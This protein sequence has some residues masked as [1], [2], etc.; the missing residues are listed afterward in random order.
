MI[1]TVV[2]LVLIINNNSS[3]DS[4]SGSRSSSISISSSICSCSSNKNVKN[5]ASVNNNYSGNNRCRISNNNVSLLYE[6]GCNAR[7]R[8]RERM[9]SPKAYN[10]TYALTLY[11]KLSIIMLAYQSGLS[12]PLCS[13]RQWLSL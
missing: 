3:C 13:L 11:D 5:S 8:A 2:V 9:A 4:S 12:E 6:L 1:A 10:L 7:L